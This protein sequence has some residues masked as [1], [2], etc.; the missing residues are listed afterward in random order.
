MKKVEITQDL[1]KILLTL[2]TMAFT[3]TLLQSLA[4][5]PCNPFDSRAFKRWEVSLMLTEEYGLLPSPC[6]QPRACLEDLAIHL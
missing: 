6:L 3:P 4:H 1:Q 2:V 5:T